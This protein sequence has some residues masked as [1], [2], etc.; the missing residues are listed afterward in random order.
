MLRSISRHQ[1]P[2]K[3]SM[4]NRNRKKNK[5]SYVPDVIQRYSKK[6]Q[7]YYNS[8]QSEYCTADEIHEIAKKV[9]GLTYY[10][11]YEQLNTSV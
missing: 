2:E 8:I 1:I 11:N 5:S 3:K 7:S 9:F 6:N 10:I 4:S